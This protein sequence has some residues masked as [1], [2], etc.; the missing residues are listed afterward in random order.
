M[1]VF[2]L[3]WK[4]FVD[5]CLALHDQCLH[6]LFLLWG[7]LLCL[8]FLARK[9]LFRLLNLDFLWLWYCRLLAFRTFLLLCR[10]FCLQFH[11]LLCFDALFWNRSFSSTFRR[12]FD[13]GLLFFLRS[14]Y[15]DFCDGLFY[16]S[17]DRYWNLYFSLFGADWF[18]FLLLSLLFSSLHEFGFG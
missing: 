14:L 16:F 8:W 10:L 15:S 2:L 12:D 11:L 9:L 18:A 5:W 13:S 3:Q 7:L 6:V 4:V 1:K 17:L